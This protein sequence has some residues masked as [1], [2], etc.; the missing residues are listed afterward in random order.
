VLSYGSGFV[1][2]AGTHLP[3]H[4]EFSMSLAK[5]FGERFSVAFTAQNLSDSRYLIDE[6]NTFGGTHWNYPRQFTGEIRYRFHY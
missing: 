2:G 4:T 1:S 5:A 3:G 6:S